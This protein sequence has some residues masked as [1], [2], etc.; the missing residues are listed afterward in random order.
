MTNP[1]FPAN[2][3]TTHPDVLEAVRETL[4]RKAEFLEKA[5][6]VSQK[7]LGDP[8]GGYF[9]GR[10]FATIHFTGLS[11]RLAQARGVTLPGQ[12]KKPVQDVIAPYKNNPAVEDFNLSYRAAPIP[13]RGNN[14]WG[15]SH[16]GT[17]LIFEHDGAVYSHF[18]FE[19]HP[20]DDQQVKEMEKYG[21]EEILGSTLSLA[22]EAANEAMGVKP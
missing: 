11:H 2:A 15:I 1:Q 10:D 18:A 20:M 17:G 13:G 3:M 16:M 22:I 6:A 4:R 12:W 8:Q 7:Y 14:V 19:R 21:W 9:N 5:R